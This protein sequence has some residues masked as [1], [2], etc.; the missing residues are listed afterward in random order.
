[1]I[2]LKSVVDVGIMNVEI[3][4]SD[5]LMVIATGKTI[6]LQDR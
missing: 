4:K 2:G 3:M 5:S 6:K 1:M